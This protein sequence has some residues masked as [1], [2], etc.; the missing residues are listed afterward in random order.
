LKFDLIAFVI[1]IVG[2][3]FLSLV[4]ADVDSVEFLPHL[5]YVDKVVHCVFYIGFSWLLGRVISA[6]TQFVAKVLIPTVCYG[7]LMEVLQDAMDLGRHFD[8]F[9]II[10]NI[11]GALIG[12]ILIYRSVSQ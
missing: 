5:P 4:P 3:T 1:W 9:D 8:I 7:I 6:H 11:I 2:V 12:T 10:A